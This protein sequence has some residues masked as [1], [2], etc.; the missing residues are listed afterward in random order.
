MLFKKTKLFKIAGFLCLVMSAIS[1]GSGILYH[2]G[3]PSPE[4]FITEDLG[5]AAT[6]FTIT[7]IVCLFLSIKKTK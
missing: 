4:N 1:F 2:K 7:A 6:C 5:K 3:E